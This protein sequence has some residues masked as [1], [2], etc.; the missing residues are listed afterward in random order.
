VLADTHFFLWYLQAS[1]RLADTTRVLLDNV[2]ARASCPAP[3]TTGRG[4]AWPLPI[5]EVGTGPV[6]CADG[7]ATAAR[8]RRHLS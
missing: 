3:V 5:P 1:P 7:T 4:C 6:A 2:T 8:R